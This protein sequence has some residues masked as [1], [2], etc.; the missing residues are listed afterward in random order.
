LLR[1]EVDKP[2]HT[3]PL[4]EEEQATSREANLDLVA[5]S[6]HHRPRRAR[7]RYTHQVE[8]D[9]GISRS[10]GK[11]WMRKRGRLWQ[12]TRR[13]FWPSTRQR[14]ATSRECLR[15]EVL[16]QVDILRIM[17]GK[18]G[19][20]N[21][22]QANGDTSNLSLAEREAYAKVHTHDKGHTTGRG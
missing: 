13:R 7:I 14:L 8:V 6:E 17:T 3:S 1:L 20:G 2:T 12:S 9:L 5:L 22:A 16:D 21:Y 19:M 4:V 15:R 18:G 10:R 11:A